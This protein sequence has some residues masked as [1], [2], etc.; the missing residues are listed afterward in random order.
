[1][2]RAFGFIAL[3]LAV[4]A[5]AYLFSQQAAKSVQQAQSFRLELPAQAPPRSLD[6]DEAKRAVARLGSLAEEPTPS[7]EE[8]TTIAQQAA[9]WAAGSEP[10]SADYRLAVALRTACFELSLSGP[11]PDNPHRK[12]ARQ[13]LAI[14]QEVLGG[15]SSGPVTRGVQDQLKNLQVQRGEEL[16]QGLEQAP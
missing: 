8:L 6:W 15:R 13:E 2:G 10:G 7:R 16:T 9:S 11:E 4:A 3:L 14:A 5:A 12:R 1:M